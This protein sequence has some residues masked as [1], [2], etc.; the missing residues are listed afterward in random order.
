[1]REYKVFAGSSGK[2]FA[3]KMCE[4]LGITLGNSEVF[5]FSEGNIFVKV[6]ETVRQKDVYIVQPMGLTPN[7]DLVEI[8]F[9]LDALQ[10]SSARSVTVVMPYFSYAKGDKKD[11]PRTSI[12]ARVCAECMEL[13]GADHVITM[14]LHS[15]QIQGFF[16]RQ[17]DN[18][19]AMPLLAEYIT[20]MK[21]DNFVIASPDAG[22]AKQARLFADKLGVDV[23]IGDKSRKGHDENAEI[24]QLIGDVKD[25]N[26]VIVDDFSISGGTLVDMC[27]MLKKHGAKQVFACLSHALLS[28]KGLDKINNSEIEFVMTTDTI[29]NPLIKD[30]KKFRIVSAAPLFAEA[31]DR[32]NRGDTVSEITKKLPTRILEY[33]DNEK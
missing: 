6:N 17:V 21:L 22:Y 3:E 8:L 5:K 26:V 7:D 11:E 20:H 31:V 4:Y 28:Q 9:W 1:M 12:R 14:D 25:K 10:R 33:I 16:K 18:L 27:R 2:E 24:L 30:Q 19:F 29:N 23:V 13:A 15:P 32:I